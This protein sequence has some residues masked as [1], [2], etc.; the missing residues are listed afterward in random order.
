MCFAPQRSALFRHLNLEKWSVNCVVCTCWLGN[1]LRATTRAIFGHRNFQKWSETVSFWQFWLGNVLLART[2]CTFSTSQL[3]K[4]VREWCIFVHFDLEMC[5]APQRC[6][7]FHLSSSQLAPLRSRKSMEKHSKS[8][9]SYLFAHLHLLASH[10]FSYLS[11]S[12]LF[13]SSVTLST[14]AFPSLHIVR[15]LTSKLP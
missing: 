9:L 4:V 11:F 8:W 2:A 14:S 5:F 15:K 3:A 6:A 7:M 13:F 1:V 10:S 12:L